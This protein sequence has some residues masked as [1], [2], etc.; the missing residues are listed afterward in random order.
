MTTSGAA[1]GAGV[2]CP[3]CFFYPFTAFPSIMMELVWTTFAPPFP[4]VHRPPQPPRPISVHCMCRRAADAQAGTPAR[5]L[6]ALCCAVLRTRMQAADWGWGAA[7]VLHV[8]F[9]PPR[10][11]AA[12]GVSLHAKGTHASLLLPAGRKLCVGVVWGF[13]LLPRV[14][15]HA[16]VQCSLAI[17]TTAVGLALC[18]AAAAAVAAAPTPTL[19]GGGGSGWG[20]CQLPAPYPGHP[21]G[22][23]DYPAWRSLN[24]RTYTRYI[25]AHVITHIPFT[26][27]LSLLCPGTAAN[28]MLFSL[29]T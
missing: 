2:C 8:R 3:P 4:D 11:P 9:Y 21:Q 22:C 29:E 26:R 23:L 18:P 13:P 17:H 27:F 14:Y 12:D 5:V 28:R 7:G 25:S 15:M 1:L 10:L 6:T 16:A 19:S 24:P 20:V